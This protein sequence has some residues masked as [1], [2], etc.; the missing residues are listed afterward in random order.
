MV[1]AALGT[2][3]AAGYLLW[4]LQRTAFGTPS[5]EFADDPHIVDASREEWIAWTPMLVLILVLG[6]YPNLIFGVT[7]P[8]VEEGISE[9][10]SLDIEGDEAS[11]NFDV[12]ECERNGIEAALAAAGLALGD[13]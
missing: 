13:G 10:L 6:I 12:G 2:V 5:D 1:V 11:S 3:L 8:A 7:D 9:C 4:L